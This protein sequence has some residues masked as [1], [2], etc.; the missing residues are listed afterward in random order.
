MKDRPISSTDVRVLQILSLRLLPITVWNIW[1]VWSGL[2]HWDPSGPSLQNVRVTVIFFLQCK[3]KYA[4][5]CFM[6]PWWSSHK[7]QYLAYPPPPFRIW[8]CRPY[9]LKRPTRP[10]YT[11]S[12][13]CAFPTLFHG[14]GMPC[15][16]SPI[17]WPF[18]LCLVIFMVKYPSKLCSGDAVCGKLSLNWIR[19]HFS[20]CFLCKIPNNI[21]HVPIQLLLYPR[22]CPRCQGKAAVSKTDTFLPSRSLTF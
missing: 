19:G 9:T 18:S 2:P 14:L 1:V 17:W 5:K 4:T 13:Y 16:I 6:G 3:P 8:T 11:V 22:H 21:W 12:C 20:K 15:A 10:L 7:V